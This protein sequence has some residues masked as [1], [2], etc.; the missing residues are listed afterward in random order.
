MVLEKPFTD[1]FIERLLMSYVIYIDKN[2]QMNIFKN[3]TC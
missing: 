3:I 1:F 2:G